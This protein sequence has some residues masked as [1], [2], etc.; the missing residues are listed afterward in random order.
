MTNQLPPP[1][2]VARANVSTFQHDVTVLRCDYPLTNDIR[3]GRMPVFS[4]GAD[5]SVYLSYARAKDHLPLLQIPG[6]SIVSFEV[7]DSTT[8]ER[9]TPGWAIVVGILG[10][11][12][13]LIG[14]VF[15][16]IKTDVVVPGAMIEVVDAAGRVLAVQVAGAN[17][18][19]V[20]ALTR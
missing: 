9:R 13:F 15:F 18:A 8:V 7:R 17:A 14:I 1:K 12:F 6:T 2:P 10:L 19:Q 5:R 11:F 16:F 3:G 4:R 20:Q